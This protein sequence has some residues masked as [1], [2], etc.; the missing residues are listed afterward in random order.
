VRTF[1]HSALALPLLLATVMTAVALAGCGQSSGPGT[2][3]SGQG[4]TASGAVPAQVPASLLHAPL[5]C[6]AGTGVLII[7]RVA[8]ALTH[9][10]TVVVARCDSGAGSPPSGVYVVD[11]A[12]ASAR[13]TDTLVR[14]DQEL[15]IATITAVAGGLR[16]TGLGY[17]GVDV[18]RCCPDQHVTLD[19]RI[20]GGLLVPT[21]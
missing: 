3:A 17:S 1:P 4:A 19:W 18:P 11:G 21:A 20:E 2:S 16:A 10:A 15:Q 8:V 14:T 7:Q 12:G 6:P 13:V 9:L 5:G